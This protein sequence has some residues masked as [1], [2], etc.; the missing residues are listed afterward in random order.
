MAE[1]IVERGEWGLRLAGAVDEGS[2]EVE[3]LCLE[4]YRRRVEA[5]FAFALS[6]QSQRLGWTSTR[7]SANNT[8]TQAES[9][10]RFQSNVNAQIAL[11]LHCIDGLQLNIRLMAIKH[12]VD[13]SDALCE[14]EKVVFTVQSR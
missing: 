13:I 12:Q 7:S 2:L 14:Q 11:N 10:H 4:N 6:P 9:W 3:Q 5:E 1:V 8:V